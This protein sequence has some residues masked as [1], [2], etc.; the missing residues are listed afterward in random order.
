MIDPKYKFIVISSINSLTIHQTSRYIASRDTSLSAGLGIPVHIHPS[1]G[2]YLVLNWIIASRL[3]PD[4]NVRGLMD[5]KFSLF[6]LL[7]CSMNSETAVTM[8][9]C[10]FHSVPTLDSEQL[11]SYPGSPRVICVCLYLLYMSMT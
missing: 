4:E 2:Y 11:A 1:A 6:I 3:R 9:P 5:G 10:S 7:I 8:E